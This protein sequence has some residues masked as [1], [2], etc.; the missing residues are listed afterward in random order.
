MSKPGPRS[1][2]MSKGSQ[3]FKMT[4][5]VDLAA[6]QAGREA[7]LLRIHGLAPRSTASMDAF[8]EDYWLSYD[9]RVEMSSV[10][11]HADCSRQFAVQAGLW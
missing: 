4:W 11:G 8:V 5:Q 3:L 7:V 6:N 1:A 10:V 2:E 9:K